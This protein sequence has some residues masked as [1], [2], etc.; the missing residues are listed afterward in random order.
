MRYFRIF[1]VC[2]FYMLQNAT[3]IKQKEQPQYVCQ[4]CDYSSSRKN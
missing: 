3:D 1:F 2:S 4:I